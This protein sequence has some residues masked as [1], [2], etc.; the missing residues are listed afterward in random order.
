MCLHVCVCVCVCHTLTRVY[1]VHIEHYILYRI[2]NLSILYSA[3]SIAPVLVYSEARSACEAD[4]IDTQADAAS[5]TQTINR[6]TARRGLVCYEY[7]S[8]IHL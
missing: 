8:E 5:H 7:G 6:L 1:T 2:I 4:D 3:V